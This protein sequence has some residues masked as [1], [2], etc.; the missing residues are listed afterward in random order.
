MLKTPF[1]AAIWKCR[2]AALNRTQREFSVTS[3]TDLSRGRRSLAD[4]IIKSP[5]GF[6]GPKIRDIAPGAGRTLPM[7]AVPHA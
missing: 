7:N 2:Q 5:N 1:A 6:P 4:I 3:Q